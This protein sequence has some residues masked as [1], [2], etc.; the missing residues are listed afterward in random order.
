MKKRITWFRD[1]YQEDKLFFIECV[2]LIVVGLAI[3]TTMFYGDNF[4]IFLSAFW[5]DNNALRGELPWL[6]S[7]ANTPYGMGHQL[8]CEIWALPMLILYKIFGGKVVNSVMAI[9]WYKA[10]APFSWLYQ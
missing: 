2:A 7:S 3:F 5:T 8:I 10:I 1:K 9:L 4:A 6:V